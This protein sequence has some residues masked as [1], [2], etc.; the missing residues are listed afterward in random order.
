MCTTIILEEKDIDIILDALDAK[1]NA[2][3]DSMEFNSDIQNEIDRVRGI[4]EKASE[5]IKND[6]IMAREKTI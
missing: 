3:F 5:T 6:F 4:F 2:L 1:K